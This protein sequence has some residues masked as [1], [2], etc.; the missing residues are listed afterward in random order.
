MRLHLATITRASLLG[1][2]TGAR[3]CSGIAAQ[4]AVT[5]SLARRQP[6]R[7]LGHRRVKGLFG[8]AALGEIV[9]DKLPI[10]P[11]RL[12][13]SGLVARLGL[14]AAT[15]LLVARA[16]DETERA[17]RGPTAYEEGPAEASLPPVEPGSAIPPAALGA[18]GV[19]VGAS[20]A[21]AFLGHAWRGWA[22]R[23]FGRDWPGALLEDVVVLALAGVATRS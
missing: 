20:L 6:E 17:R 11:S 23:S 12:A 19:A 8:L 21:S 10:A 3:S 14:A 18:V 7:A 22:A 15:A 9:G 16:A 4:V 13:P 2:A 1:L 5:P